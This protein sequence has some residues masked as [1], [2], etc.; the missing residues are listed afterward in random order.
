MIS[1][2]GGQFEEIEEGSI[3]IRPNDQVKV[4]ARGDTRRWNESGVVTG[5]FMVSNDLN[6][7]ER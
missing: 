4:Y 6:S 7:L 3:Q 5:R 1:V 2:N